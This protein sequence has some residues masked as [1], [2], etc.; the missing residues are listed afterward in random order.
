MPLNASNPDVLGTLVSWTV[1]RV[2]LD[3]G[4]TEE[5]RRGW[6]KSE[7][8]FTSLRLDSDGVG[9]LGFMRLARPR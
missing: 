6:E 3:V 7:S 9:L 1:T 8:W 4:K 2:G 5:K